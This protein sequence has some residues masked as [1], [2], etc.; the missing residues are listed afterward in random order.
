VWPR[1]TVASPGLLPGEIV[2]DE[3]WIDAGRD[4]LVARVRSA[5][6]ERPRT[7]PVSC[8]QPRR[9]IFHHE[10]YRVESVCSALM[11][12]A[13]RIYTSF[14]LVYMGRGRTVLRIY[15]N[16][17]CAGEV[18][19]W[20]WLAALNVVGGYVARC[21]HWYAGARKCFRSIDIR[22]WD[23]FFCFN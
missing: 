16:A 20:L 9:R 6:G 4:D 11:S 15:T 10:T 22:G 19:P 23:G 3:I 17:R 1:R 5:H 13:P 2:H 18:W 8:E 7:R 14:C 21:G 12:F